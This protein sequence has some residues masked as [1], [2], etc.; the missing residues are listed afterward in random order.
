MPSIAQFQLGKIFSFELQEQGT[1]VCAWQ[2]PTVFK[3]MKGPNFGFTTGESQLDVHRSR[4]G[5]PRK[6]NW[7]R[8]TS[9]MHTQQD[10]NTEKSSQF[11]VAPPVTCAY[12]RAANRYIG[13]TA[14]EPGAKPQRA[15]S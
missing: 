10:G 6:R 9:L 12:S 4:Y 14:T 13:M 3:N 15:F 8:G 7:F 11:P 5:M 1:L 2:G